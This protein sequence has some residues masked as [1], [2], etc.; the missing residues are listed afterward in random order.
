MIEKF[1]LLERKVLRKS[2]ILTYCDDLYR[3]PDG[4]EEVYDIM[5]H[6]G[7]SAV[8]PVLE[9]GRILM[10]HQYRPAVERVTTEIP[11]GKRDEG[12]AFDT[13]AARELE[14]ETGYRA[15]RLEHLITINPAIAYCS[16]KIEVYAAFD[17][18]KHEQHLD[19]DEYVE[20]EAY[21]IEDLVNMIYEGKIMDSKTIASLMAYYNKYRLT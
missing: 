13:A 8:V 19:D 9:D 21:D 17:L 10:V 11:A 16:E 1:E 2:N 20:F 3:F 15:G 7:A 18:Q 4:K 6:N 14:E 12:E 5:L